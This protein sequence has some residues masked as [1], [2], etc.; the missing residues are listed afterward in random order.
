[1]SDGDGQNG[2]LTDA[3]AMG[4]TVLVGELPS[5]DPPAKEVPSALPVVPRDLYTVGGE[6]ARGGMGKIL[7]GRD[8]RIGRPVALKQLLVK[9]PRAKQRFEREALITGRLQHPAIV[10]VY[11]AGRWPEG[12]PFYAMKLVEGEP[13]SRVIGRAKTLDQRVALLPNVIAVAH[14][15]AYAHEHRVIHRDIKPSNVLVGAFGETVVIDWGLAKDLAAEEGDDEEGGG[16]SGGGL[17]A[18]GSSSAPTVAGT[19]MGTPGFMSPEQARGETVDERADVYAIGAMLYYLLTGSVPYL[20]DAT[21][22]ARLRKGPGPGPV[23]PPTALA[24]RAPDVP[25]DLMAIVDHAMATDPAD[26]YPT[27]KELA[28]DLERFAAGQLVSVHR[29]SLGTLVSRWIRRHRAAVAVGAVMFAALCV[30]G[31]VSVVR[32]LQERNRAQRRSVDLVMQQARTS[33]RFDPTAAIAWLEEVPAGTPGRA[34][35]IERIALQAINAGVARHVLRGHEGYVYDA[36]ISTDGAAIASVGHDGKL[37]WW[38]VA[39]GRLVAEY[40]HDGPLRAVAISPGGDRVAAVGEGTGVLWTPST[41]EAR[42]LEGLTGISWG[43]EFDG[44]GSHVLGADTE[45][46][47][48]WSTA[49]GAAKELSY[50]PGM[51]FADVARSPSGDTFAVTNGSEVLL[52]TAATGAVRTLEAEAGV[53]DVE[54]SANGKWL[55]ARTFKDTVL[56]WDLSTG[57]GVDLRGHSG[58]VRSLAFSPDGSLLATGGND[59]IARVWTAGTAASEV[60]AGHDDAVSTIAFARDGSVIT[61]DDRGVAKMWD[62]SS[63]SGRSLLGHDAGCSALAVSG[64]GTTLATASYDGTVRVWAIGDMPGRIV[65]HRLSS[66]FEPRYLPDGTLLAGGFRKVLADDRELAGHGRSLS[67][68][69]ATPDGSVI[70]VGDMDGAMLA[71]DLAAGTPRDIA[72]ADHGISALAITDDGRIL[73]SAGGDPDVRLW[74][75]R[76]GEARAVRRLS[77]DDATARVRHLALV[78]GGDGGVALDSAGRMWWWSLADGEAGGRVLR[79]DCDTIAGIAVTRALAVCALSDGRIGTAALDGSAAGEW[80]GHRDAVTAIALAPDGKHLA[81]G[82]RDGIVRV[83]DVATGRSRQLWQHRFFVEDVAFSPDG[84][85]LG[86]ASSDSTVRVWDTSSWRALSLD[87]NPAAKFVAFGYDGQLAVQLGTR[88]LVRWSL[89]APTSLRDATSARITPAGI[90]TVVE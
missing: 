47:I 56:L 32:I 9:A 65:G 57:E 50:V 33:L 60:L 12:D 5:D 7:I 26:R 10:P 49:D 52:V 8:R 90:A 22:T 37:L 75:V 40:A 87:V 1:M 44:D 4:E 71:W 48:L 42:P 89:V 38:D 83:W 68:S 79:D 23:P 13:L 81:S 45:R 6:L 21:A 59:N 30:L 67:A 35:E 82:G 62:L 72:R 17:G 36:A 34:G 39:T 73:A 31:A 64:D 14:A 11:E 46:V 78:P 2:T 61:C 77:G 63:Q 54:L 41:G 51:R 3:E 53:R 43:I 29:Y 27:A 24:E 15:I 58:T 70:V 69:A 18:Y 55:A 25:P 80:A 66:S 20:D 76:T 84:A 19:A 88:A 85:W 86:S 74:D 16:I 28:V